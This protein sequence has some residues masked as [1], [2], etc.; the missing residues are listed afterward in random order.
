MS[1]SRKQ[2]LVLS[3]LG[4]IIATVLGV[5]IGWFSGHT[6]ISIVNENKKP[7]TIELAD[8]KYSIQPSD[9]KSLWLTNGSYT[10]R[11]VM[12]SDNSDISI[13]N[14][15]NTENTSNLTF[16]YSV[17]E[18]NT[19][20]DFL[21]EEVVKSS[22]CT[23]SDQSFTVTFLEDYNWAVIQGSITNQ[24]PQ[25]VIL[26]LENGTWSV[27]YGPE[28][29]NNAGSISQLGAFPPSVEELI[30]ED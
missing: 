11:T 1:L 30:N 8:K 26:R 24:E 2:I 27:K 6:K 7:I 10:Y 23:I 18:K 19:I 16:N 5:A 21:C 28:T 12:N 22:D 9:S 17:F 14:N 3:T 13:V 20:K 4:V 15:F 25:W 29:K